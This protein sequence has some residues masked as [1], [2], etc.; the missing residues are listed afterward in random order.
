[1]VRVGQKRIYTPYMAVYLVTSLPKV[2]YIHGLN[3]VLSS[4]I[5]DVR[6][7]PCGHKPLYFEE[8][9][10]DRCLGKVR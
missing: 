3:M 6:Q 9:M 4:L 1:M 2:L 10:H 7:V 8:M 5:K